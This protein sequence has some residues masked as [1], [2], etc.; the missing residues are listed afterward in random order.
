MK[1]YRG[2]SITFR[3]ATAVLSVALMAALLETV[4]DGFLYPD[5]QTV[6]ARRDAIAVQADQVARAR[7]LGEGQVKSA[8][9]GRVPRL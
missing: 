7:A 8:S 2:T 1:T 6:A 9:S 5:P 4:T 3:I